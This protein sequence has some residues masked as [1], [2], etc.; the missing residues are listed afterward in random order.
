MDLRCHVLRCHPIPRSPNRHN[1]L[2]LASDIADLTDTTHSTQ[3]IKP[4]SPPLGGTQTHSPTECWVCRGFRPI[5][6]IT[7][8]ETPD[9]HLSFPLLLGDGQMGHWSGGEHAV[10]LAPSSG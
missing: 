9:K 6:L 7:N 10:R 4:Q 3:W 2:R 5:Q 1:R 8:R